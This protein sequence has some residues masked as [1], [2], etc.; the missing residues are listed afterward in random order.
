M[1]F[2]WQQHWNGVKSVSSEHRKLHRH[3][4][5]GQIRIS[6]GKWSAKCRTTCHQVCIF[7][8]YLEYLLSSAVLK[9]IKSPDMSG[10]CTNLEER[11]LLVQSAL[12]GNNAGST[13]SSAS[14]STKLHPWI[15][16]NLYDDTTEILNWVANDT[17]FSGEHI[18]NRFHLSKHRQFFQRVD[19]FA[20]YFNSYVRMPSQRLRCRVMHFKKQQN[21]QLE[22]TTSV[23][24]D[25]CYLYNL[26]M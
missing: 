23:T 12:K 13:W 22:V 6:G 21:N 18:I 24:L 8:C 20:W 4:T 2:Y 15:P 7:S 17:K 9:M 25:Q 3:W 1:K 11:Q 10:C 5:P 19:Q 14:P 26:Y 16:E